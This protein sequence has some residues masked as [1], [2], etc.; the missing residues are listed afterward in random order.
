MY[1]LPLSTGGDGKGFVTMENILVRLNTTFAPQGTFGTQRNYSMPGMGGRD[2]VI[3]YDAAVCLE[4]Y[5]PWIVEVYNSSFG[6]PSSMKIVDKAAEIKDMN[7]QQVKEKRLGKP[8]SDPLVKRALNST[9]MKPAYIVG[10]QNSV[11]QI[12]KDNGRDYDYVPSPTLISFTDGDGP[13]GYTELSEVYYAKARALA[14]ASNV[15]PYF[16]GSGLTVARRYQDQVVTTAVISTLIMVS[17]MFTVF[18]MGLISALFVPRLPLDTPRRG[19]DLYS[20]FSAF[21]A[22]ELIAEYPAG[23]SKNMELRDIIDHTAELKFR[24][25]A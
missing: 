14:D 1:S 19:F 5:E 4:L 20:W 2:T 3:G 25:V 18:L 24:Y 6:F 16:A 12:L 9:N 8:V 15:L 7:T 10:H 22:R 11:N 21:Y 17:I 23:I 13:F